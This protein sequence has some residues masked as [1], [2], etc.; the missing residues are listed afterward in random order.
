MGPCAPP[1]REGV[2][3]A[4]W[5]R[6]SWLAQAI[7]AVFHRQLGLQLRDSA[8]LALEVCEVSEDAFASHALEATQVHRLPLDGLCIRAVGHLNP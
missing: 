3:G 8:G 7:S 6:V 1:F 2:T 5:R 4:G